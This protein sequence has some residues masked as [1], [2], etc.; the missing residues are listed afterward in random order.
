MGMQCVCMYMNVRIIYACIHKNIPT[1]MHL[2][3][4]VNLYVYPN[5]NIYKQTVS[6]IDGWRDG[7]WVEGWRVSGGGGS[8]VTRRDFSTQ[9]PHTNCMMH[10]T[11]PQG[12][13]PKGVCA[14]V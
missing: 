4:F 1:R 3:P 11:D 10:T 12:T 14:R 5:P 7:G 6:K 2:Y 13:D 8:A 9:T